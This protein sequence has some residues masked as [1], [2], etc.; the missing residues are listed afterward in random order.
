MQYLKD[1]TVTPHC[2]GGAVGIIM[3]GGGIGRSATSGGEG[4]LV[5]ARVPALPDTVRYC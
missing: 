3:G 2:K 1:I 4:C 5:L